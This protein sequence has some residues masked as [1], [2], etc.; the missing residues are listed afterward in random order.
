MLRDMSTTAKSLFLPY[1]RLDHRKESRP[2]QSEFHQP[3]R[4][5][6]CGPG[7]AALGIPRTLAPPSTGAR[8]PL[9]QGPVKPV[10]EAANLWGAASDPGSLIV[11]VNEFRR[12]DARQ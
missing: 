11:N 1:R 6:D 3:D 5:I 2:S 10:V 12:P 4:P 8:I 7:P 9:D